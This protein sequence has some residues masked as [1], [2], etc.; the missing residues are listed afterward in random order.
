MY[1]LVSKELECPPTSRRA[2]YI[3]DIGHEKIHKGTR[4]FLIPEAVFSSINHNSIIIRDTK[5]IHGL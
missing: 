1:I 3:I 2:T 4:D 5:L